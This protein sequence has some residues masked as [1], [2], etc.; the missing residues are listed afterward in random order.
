MI[1]YKPWPEGWTYGGANIMDEYFESTY[2]NKKFLMIQFPW[3][4]VDT[5]DYEENTFT[6]DSNHKP[7]VVAK[8][9]L[10]EIDF[11]YIIIYEP[12]EWTFTIEVIDDYYDF[13]KFCNI[14][15]DKII[16][17]GANHEVKKYY[18]YAC[19]ENKK[20]FK[21]VAFNHCLISSLASHTDILN[22]YTTEVKFDG[23]KLFICPMNAKGDHRE[24]LYD[25]LKDNDLLKSGH[26][27]ARWR[28]VYLDEQGSATSETL[29]Q[30][31]FVESIIPFYEDSFCSVV[32]E[33][34]FDSWNVRFTEKFYFPIMYNRPF[35]ILGAPK[36]ISWIKEYGFKTFPELFDEGYDDEVDLR[37]RTKLI[38][39]NLKRLQDK[40]KKELQDLLEI[41]KPKIIHNKNLLKKY[42]NYS[43]NQGGYTIQELFG[44]MNKPLK[45][46]LRDVL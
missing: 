9:S 42:A 16:F 10:S 39:K 41:V 4:C 23:T 24:F 31:N 46:Q 5:E 36:L 37:E 18:D 11:D 40:S 2:P 25:G 32:T 28:G 14:P 8:Q 12:V 38:V 1:Q 29:P 20:R 26:V 19:L 33:S 3:P 44:V 35:M 43:M 45:K 13:F 15:M 22:Q 30:N 34:E 7:W 27:S 17:Q 21:S 6:K